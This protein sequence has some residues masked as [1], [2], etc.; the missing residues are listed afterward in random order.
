[1]ADNSDMEVMTVLPKELR[2]G[3]PPTMPQAR[4][5]LF[6]QQ[7]TLSAY[8]PDDQIQINIPRLQ[9]SYL[10]KDSYLQFRLNGQ[11]E[12]AALPSVGGQQT[13]APDLMLDDAGAWGLFERI[14][15]FDYLGST[16][17]ENLDGLPQLSSLLIDM[18]AEFT[19]PDHEGSACH[20]LEG[21]YSSINSGDNA[22]EYVL[23]ADNDMPITA[24]SPA[25]P[26]ST[27][28]TGATIFR[29]IMSL[30]GTPNIDVTLAAA[31]YSSTVSAHDARQKAVD[32]WNAALAAATTP[33]CPLRLRFSALYPE[34][35]EIY[36]VTTASTTGFQFATNT[37][38]SYVAAQLGF[39]QSATPSKS[40]KGGA[41]VVGT[42]GVSRSY[43]CGGKQLVANGQSYT[44]ELK[45]F[46]WQFSIPLP[47]F[48]GFL[49]K[50]MV[51]LHNGFTI[52]LTIA[53][54]YKPMF[55]APKQVPI[56]AYIPAN[57]TTNNT[58]Q[59]ATLL[60]ENTNEPTSSGTNPNA[61]ANFNNPTEFWWN[62]T[63]VALVCQ[64]LELGPVAESMILSSTQGQPLI[65]HSKQFRNYRGTVGSTA[66]EFQLPLN[67]NV[68]S[69]TDVLWFMR[70]NS[71]E[72][73]LSLSS[74]GA[75][76][77]NFLYRWEF[78]YGST[79]LPQ[80]QGIQS[81]YMTGPIVPSGKTLSSADVTSST[82]RGYTEC[83]AELL[84]SRPCIPERGRLT[85]D[86]FVT[87]ATLG[88]GPFSNYGNTP[89]RVTDL[90]TG[91]STFEIG[92]FAC[93]LNMEL[94]TG[95]TGDLICG[96]N[97]N[98]MNTQIRGYFHP[99][100]LTSNQRTPCSIDAY[101]EFDA[102]VNISPGIAT[103]VSY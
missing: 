72:N 62:L 28:F 67:L 36:C 61:P 31:T 102:F 45:S 85:Y 16:V 41:S 40:S 38:Q 26:W 19:D 101:A 73:V 96:L 46:S 81:M 12:P 64:I 11:Y 74:V 84:K 91:A 60:I 25:G 49:S 43:Y 66:A 92:K 27:N 65:V 15:V 7:S 103:T 21:S 18:G 4:S 54:K 47:S 71:S 70:P 1:M 39:N 87:T 98:G 51:P 52:V 6:R 10:R 35:V 24:S 77:R 97:T 33:V 80:S 86:N 94:T 56:I 90:G 55:A 34:R 68:A 58:E 22:T 3:A 75:R 82:L 79:V 100:F 93:G 42:N 48:L 78:Q 30:T 37:G 53:S 59:T 63:D 17:L 76:C 32:A 95:K 50:K 20:G 89:Y 14:E 23:L 2:L 83:F 9:R 88:Y 29:Y 69:L 57:P 44:P 5:Y 8:N 99:S 13:Y